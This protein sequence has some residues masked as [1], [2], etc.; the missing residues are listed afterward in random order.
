MARWLGHAD[1]SP[2]DPGPINRVERENASM[3]DQFTNPLVESV[4]VDPIGKVV[5]LECTAEGMAV[6]TIDRPADHNALN[7]LAIEGLTEAF[8]TLQGAEGVRIVFLRGAGGTFCAGADMA[9][10]SVALADWT[11]DDNR[12]EARV[13]AAMLQALADIPAVTVALVEGAARSEGVGLVA[14]CD[15]A[16]A[17]ADATFAFAET[18]RG[19]IPA[20][21]AP[22]VVEALGP[23]MAKAL[24]VTG[25]TIDAAQAER[26]G[27]VHEI[28]A[29]AAGMDHSMDR[30]VDWVIT[31]A[32]GAIAEVKRLVRDLADRPTDRGSLTEDLA[33]RLAHRRVSEEGREG[34]EALLSHRKPGWF[35]SDRIP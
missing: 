22:Y 1:P 10:L 20:M 26:I 7:G 28:A 8:E 23:R 14:A 18:K 27:L 2:G 21:I 16:V 5:R 25:Q 4:I 19:S 12:S 6:V 13:F 33:V 9:E 34:V 17:A 3:T 31:G 32:P 29:D 24:F 15:I 11:E 35:G 30:L